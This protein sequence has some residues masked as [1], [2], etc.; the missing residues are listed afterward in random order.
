MTY[1][2]YHHRLL[3]QILS[4]RTIEVRSVRAAN[5]PDLTSF[6]ND[7]EFNITTV[8]S[9]SC[10]NLRGL[11]SL[12]AGNPGFLDFRTAPLSTFAN[13]SCHNTTN[14][15][16]VTLKCNNCRL[17][18]DNFYTSWQFLDLPNMPAS[19]V[20][21][22]FNVSAMDRL[23]K[24]HVSYVS[25]RLRNGSNTGEKFVTFRGSDPN[26]LQFNLCPRIYRN[27]HDLKLIQPSF[28]KFLPGS[29]FNERNQLRASLENSSNGLVNITLHVNFLSS[30]IIE[31]DDQNILGPGE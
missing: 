26:I 21:F 22:E 8:S 13:F 20:G 1:F 25:G 14:G 16:M 6:N 30:Y 9:M 28:H 10:S 27:K 4:K 23:H 17:I 11:G 7:M 2:D 12:L 18:R 29:S 15:P 31:I 3:Y 19:A 24:K 5:A